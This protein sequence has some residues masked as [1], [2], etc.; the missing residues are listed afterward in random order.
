VICYSGELYSVRELTKAWFFGSVCV[1]S[2]IE[3]IHSQCF[4]GYGTRGALVVAFE[5]RS[6]LQRME[7]YWFGIAGIR[8]LCIPASVE[9]LGGGVMGLPRYIALVTFESSVA[10]GEPDC[11]SG[12]GLLGAPTFLVGSGNRHF[13]VVGHALMN[14]GRTTLIR[15]CGCSDPEI[16]I[17]STVEELASGSFRRLSVTTLTFAERSSLRVIGESA[18]EDCGSLASMV[19]PAALEQI[20]MSAF[21][22]C[23]ALQEL[24]F[25]RGSRLRV[26]GTGA[27]QGCRSLGL[28]VIPAAV[29]VIDKGAFSVCSALQEVRF[30]TG[31]RLQL[32]GELAFMDCP[33]LGWMDV[34]AAAVI[35]GLFLNMPQ[36][37]GDDES[38][39]IRFRFVAPPKGL[40]PPPPP[41]AA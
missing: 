41:H 1:P 24:R 12:C 25:R 16:T 2:S 11:G 9:L 27:F 3:V 29:Q 5:W 8:W 23:V 7:A 15:Y 33:Y 17:D 34:P 19:L 31:S 18:F 39:S 37:S 32:I 20:E 35:Q 6:Q 4:P 40:G 22:A 13:A 30:E 38:M 14:F 21:R 26:I 28:V 10:V 36:V